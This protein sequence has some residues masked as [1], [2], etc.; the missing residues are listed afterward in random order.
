MSDFYLQ[1]LGWLGNVFFVYGA[2]L[3]TQ[4]K[5]RSYAV[6][7]LCGNFAYILQGMFYQNWSLVALS[8]VLGTLSAAILLKWKKDDA[9]SPS[10]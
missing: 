4:K 3:L 8:M 5:P 9:S 6:W 1:L 2:Y 7:N 10:V